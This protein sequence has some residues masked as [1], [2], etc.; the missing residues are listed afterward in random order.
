MKNKINEEQD[1]K[2]KNKKRGGNKKW[3]SKLEEKNE[4]KF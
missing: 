3:G 4:I 1:K 2:G